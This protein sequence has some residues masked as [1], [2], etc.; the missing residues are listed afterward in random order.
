MSDLFYFED[1]GN[2]KSEDDTKDKFFKFAE[3]TYTKEYY[4]DYKS[5]QEA[6]DKY[7][8][9]WFDN[10]HYEDFRGK[11]KPAYYYTKLSPKREVE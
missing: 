4:K 3:I 11:M 8:K 10:N 5:A 1:E 7:F 6:G 9:D 2:V